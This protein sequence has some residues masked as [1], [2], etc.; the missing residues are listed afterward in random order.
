MEWFKPLCAVSRVCDL[1][2]TTPCRKKTNTISQ[3]K[4]VCDMHP[5]EWGTWLLFQMFQGPGGLRRPGKLSGSWNLNQV[6]RMAMIQD[7][8]KRER[9]R[10][11]SKRKG[12]SGHAPKPNALTVMAFELALKRNMGFHL[13]ML[14]TFL[15]RRFGDGLWKAFE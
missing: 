7:Q 13:S 3:N 2:W 12:E 14:I 10:L 8:Q 4:S 6:L 1:N 9:H 11:M 15:E 5:H